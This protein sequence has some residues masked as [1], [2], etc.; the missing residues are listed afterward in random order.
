MI[1]RVSIVALA[2]LLISGT[3]V[4]AA[5][6]QTD[7]AAR[8]CEKGFKAL[9]AGDATR[10]ETSFEKALEQAPSYPDAH[11]GMGHVAMKDGRFEEA[12]SKYEAARDGWS[13]MGEELFD[14]KMQQYHAGR[15]DIPKLQQEAGLVI[16]GQIKMG[17]GDR[18]L[19]LKEIDDR[20]RYLETM[21]P[22]TKET[23]EAPGEVDFHLGNAL[24]R[25]QRWEEAVEAYESCIKKSPEFAQVHNNIA[26][27]YWRAGR[28]DSALASLDKAEEMGL[29]VNPKFR[30]DI[31]KSRKPDKS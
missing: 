1:F 12:L 15:L 23:A 16:S 7:K 10:A 9:A 20:I 22:P 24:S 25:L 27:A 21:A 6:S 5:T 8:L 2:V 17:D 4:F 13:E 31:E 28:I 26:L 29:Q 14:K 30:A 18:R 3:L 11:L 19:R